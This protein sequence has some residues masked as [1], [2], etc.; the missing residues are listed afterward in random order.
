MLKSLKQKNKT[1]I[2]ELITDFCLNVY[3]CYK[4]H[5]DNNQQKRF[6]WLT[7]MDV[8]FC[9]FQLMYKICA[10]RSLFGNKIDCI[11]RLHTH[12]LSRTCDYDGIKLF[13]SFLFYHM[14]DHS[15]V[16]IFHIDKTLNTECHRIRSILTQLLCLTRK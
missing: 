8:R 15:S 1:K 9:E 10:S 5:H 11:L 6:H 12:M 13:C 3:L 14:P 2:S 4:N 7:L 16:N